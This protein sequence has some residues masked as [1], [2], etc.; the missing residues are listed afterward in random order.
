[1]RS[2]RSLLLSFICVAIIGFTN[3]LQAQQGTIA[4]RVTMANSGIALQGAQIQIEGG[5]VASGMIS[6][7]SGVYRLAVPAGTYAVT[8]QFQGYATRTIENVVVTAGETTLL[9]FSLEQEVIGL[10][11]FVVSASKKAE[12]QVETPATT[13]VV[14]S[15]IIAEKPTQT[16][17][18]HLRMAPGVD[19]ITQGI[20]STNVSVRGFNN[21]FSGSLHALTDHR[22]AGV[23]SL[24]VNLLH[25]IPSN[26]ED[27]ERIEV[28]L[29]PG[30]ALYG[31]NTANGVLH[32]FTRSPLDPASEKTTV[33]LGGGNRGVFQGSFR[34]AHLINSRLG[35]KLSGQY[36]RGDDWQY[37][38]PTEEAARD[39][40]DQN[41]AECKALLMARGYDNG[42][43][44]QGCDRVGERDYD[45]ERYAIE[46]RADYRFAEAG[47]AIL[48]YG[49]TSSSGIELTGLGA[50][51]TVDWIYQFFQ[52]R[53]NK[54]RFFA[55]AYYNT[56][57]AGDSWL[58]RDGVPLVDKS[59]LFVAQAQH[60]MSFFDDRQDFTYGFDY[61]RTRPD[62]ESTINGFY[63]DEDDV[64][65][66]GIYLQSKTVLSDQLDLILAGRMDDHSML[67]EKVWSPRAALVFKPVENQSVRFTYNRA[68][69]TPTTLNYFLDISA[70]VAPNTTLASLG[71]RLRAVGTG[72]N[73]FS[74]QNADGSL[75]GMHSPFAPGP[76]LPADPSVMWP[77]AMGVL[78]A[79]I[80]QGNLPAE[81]AALL[82]VLA[83]L[84]PTGDDLGIDL[85]DAA[86]GQISPLAG[87]TLPGVPSL[88]ESYTE[89][90]EIG[91]QGILG[92][93][94]QLA[95]D[96][97]YT[98]KNNFISPLVVTN[99]LLLLNGLDVAAF[100]G[101]PVVGAIT[102][103]LIGM[104][105]DP[106]AALEAAKA[107]AA[108]IVP[109]LA[110]GIGGVPL[111]VAG[112]EEIPHNDADLIVTYRNIGDIDFWGADVSAALHLNNGITVNGS[113][114]HVSED[115][116]MLEVYDPLSLNAPKSKGSFGMA[117]RA[118]NGFYLDW[119]VRI[120]NQF[121]AESAG[122]VGT[123]CRQD[124]GAAAGLF[125]EDCI[126]QATLVDL[127]IG[128]K[129]PTTAATLQLAVTNLFDTP[130]RSF[131][132]V[133]DI[134][135]FALL[136]VKYDL[137]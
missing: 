14:G 72:P 81:L 40:A 54:D 83:G 135:R 63:E 43:S 45:L 132:G 55:Q 92:G 66:W 47:T 131:V 12:K 65:E 98:K 50:G 1:M 85:L 16:P 38:D 84:T 25:F 119:L 20:Q 91:W 122:Y 117:Y 97:Y 108:V 123:R 86:N 71:Y 18:D 10:G 34:T 127:N 106:A 93:K 102:Q 134:G 88:A 130:Y 35:V 23:P 48:T 107:Q 75:K 90:F 7:A 128:Y 100:I 28:V 111:G 116:F 29:G 99:P 80:Q 104:G 74:F 24:R 133:P 41:P 136:R 6:N 125:D 76:M 94:L 32:M 4:G 44:Q 121:P 101:A 110:A 120:N 105:M 21:I 39:F 42:L 113:Y 27:L 82:P 70:G 9:D 62:T 114:S 13:Y 137:F 31:P 53:V 61:F 56:S 124:P 78:Q 46:A 2:F 118:E 89:T 58:L 19:I 26:D 115:W 109:Q 8:T 73:G 77:I 129:I 87:T 57:D 103:Q 15:Q 60:G 68:F 22:L 96:A 3:P 30:S 95:A 37:T 17:L 112:T 69:S 51:Q 11:G 33:T 52:G 36:L 49:R 67:E 59:S 64:D 126:E 5:G 79:Q